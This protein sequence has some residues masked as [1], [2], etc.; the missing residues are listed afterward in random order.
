MQVKE[1]VELNRTGKFE[2]A[3]QLGMFREGVQNSNLCGWFVFTQYSN[4]KA[5]ELG[6]VEWLERMRRGLQLP[7]TGSIS[8]LIAN[9]GHGKSHFGVV[10]ANCFGMPND[11]EE[12]HLALSQLRH[13]APNEADAFEDFR[14]GQ[15]K[16]PYF[17]ICLQGDN[18]PTLR[19]A[20]FQ[21]VERELLR[22]DETKEKK[23]PLWHRDAL[24]WLR[25][26]SAE[27]LSKANEWLEKHGWDVQHL[28][29]RLDDLDARSEVRER[30]RDLSKAVEG[31]TVDFGAESSV[32][33]LL[34]W[35][36]DTFC[37]SDG[38]LSGLVV[39]FD[40]FHVFIDSYAK[41]PEKGNPLQNLLN[42]FELK[43][44]QG[45][46]L[47]CA[48]ATMDPTAAA[49]S[50]LKRTGG[51]PQNIGKELNRIGT[52]LRFKCE[53]EAVLDSMLRQQDEAWERLSEHCRSPLARATTSSQ[54]V[55]RERFDDL[56]WDGEEVFERVTKGCFP[57]H[58]LTTSLL[59]N[60]R[61][62]AIQNSRSVLGFVKDQYE[63]LAEAD[64]IVGDWPNWIYG[65][66]C[67][68]TFHEMF[69]ERHIARYHAVD[70]RL[71]GDATDEQLRVLVAML[72]IMAGGLPTAE[73]G[74]EQLVSDLSGLDIETVLE[75]LDELHR[76][77][78]I[79][80]EP[81][82]KGYSLAEVGQAKAD[83]RKALNE[84][85][86]NL[87]LRQYT[88]K[89]LT[90]RLRAT[91]GPMTTL[92]QP[93]PMNI[94]WGEKGDW[95][96][97]RFLV[98]RAQMSEESLRPILRIWQRDP[99]NGTRDWERAIE[100]IFVPEEV[101]DV[102]WAQ[103]HGPQLLASVTGIDRPPVLLSVMKSPNP[104]LYESLRDFLATDAIPD[105]TRSALGD[106][107]TKG[108][109]EVT[110]AAT[111]A[112]RKAFS[113]DSNFIRLVSPG[114]KDTVDALDSQNADVV[115]KVIL[116]GSYS[117]RPPKF[118]PIYGVG[119]NNHRRASIE[120]AQRLLAGN[121]A[122]YLNPTGAQ[123]QAADLLRLYLFESW[124]VVDDQYRLQYPSN[125]GIAGMWE[126]LSEDVNPAAG[127]VGLR[128]TL[129]KLANPVF[130]LDT[131]TLALVV[132]GW[133]GW[134]K[135]KLKLFDSNGRQLAWDELRNHPQNGYLGLL[136]SLRI[137]RQDV[138]ELRETIEIIFK[139]SSQV[140]AIDPATARDWVTALEEYAKVAEDGDEFKQRSTD[141]LTE[142][143]AD[144][145]KASQYA[146]IRTKAMGI[147]PGPDLTAVYEVIEQLPK[148]EVGSVKEPEWELP[149]KL[150]ER[151]LEGL[152]EWIPEL[153]LKAARVRQREDIG[154]VRS[155]LQAV[156]K[157][158]ET[159]GILSLTKAADDALSLLEETNRGFDKEVRQRTFLEKVK[160]CKPHLLSLKELREE[161]Q[162]LEREAKELGD[163]MENVRTAL[164]SKLAA[165]AG[166]IQELIARDQS[167]RA[168][169]D[170]AKNLRSVERLLLD[171][172]NYSKRLSGT[173]EL[174]Q[175]E[176]VEQEAESIGKLF[177]WLDSLIEHVPS[178]KED[179]EKAI[180]DVQ[181]LESNAPTFGL[182]E[183]CP[184]IV[185]RLQKELNLRESKARKAY[186]NHVGVLGRKADIDDI[187]EARRYLRKPEEYLPSDLMPDLE[188]KRKAIDELLEVQRVDYIKSMA[189][190]VKDKASLRELLEFIRQLAGGP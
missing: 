113:A 103:E 47:F 114:L 44:N 160:G 174:K 46:S 106:Q 144:I 171:C 66:D 82:K 189:K 165:L 100:V 69:E 49:Q 3:I 115:R 109:E 95:A 18:M 61:F 128:G 40:E 131:C 120:V 1:V 162:E 68:D 26:L 38:P 150:Y 41:A 55:F 148:A 175:G 141:R 151:F 34:Q 98:T 94:D 79:E 107:Y 149:S 71:G 157:R 7:E 127:T 169:L 167:I 102:L 190:K 22:H 75:T 116:Q 58:P 121:A 118:S 84:T 65:T 183:H 76:N 96:Y 81:L 23:P 139:T 33:D 176:S 9:Y 15:Y 138:G 93:R 70:D 39:L 10:A 133:L 155:R 130:G 59:S 25:Q 4:D 145:K 29:K 51:D 60:L 90:D 30:C 74:Y 12:F 42:V 101:D 2:R 129:R 57:L 87:D 53:M 45:R 83:F 154:L 179:L 16:R 36:L 6:S 14:G 111:E 152:S 119:A 180:S 24:A 72:L 105:Q 86:A 67:F 122:E 172:S 56:G 64:A 88:A 158:F 123:S 166:E 73:V 91:N 43:K 182:R 92:L 164:E 178:A 125:Q 153:L 63:R 140:E 54:R 17:V 50:A 117:G 146:S 159:A 124:G 168:Q 161:Q 186:D 13:S 27:K 19:Q 89:G 185:I 62:R 11:S 126:L 80:R 31:H 173:P 35:V 134:Y 181:V 170:T 188:A 8:C 5:K 135:S 85:L 48:L 37:G 156:R 78:Y 136:S 52:R 99:E 104:E 108:R 97:V 110:K 132:S 77:G 20:V 28:D 21:E 163:L 143:T 184:A 177:R 112:A 187:E 142:L 137:R 147:R 32:Q